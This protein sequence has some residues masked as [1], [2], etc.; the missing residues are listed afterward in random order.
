MHLLWAMQELPIWNT[1]DVMHVER[2]VSNNLLRYLTR[3]NDIM[4]V[5]KDMQ[6]VGVHQHLWL[7]SRPGSSNYFKPTA[8]YDF[9]WEVNKSFLEFVYNIPTP[10]WYAVA[11]RK[12]VGPK[13]LYAM[14]NHDHHV[15]VQQILRMNVRNLLQAGLRMTIIQLEQ[16]FQ[17]ICAKVLNLEDLVALWTYEHTQY[18]CLKYGFH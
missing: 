9:P 17:R 16:S 2:N 3:E 10:T 7:Q 15:M 5:W 12:H 4:E 13:R 1:L 14:K 6:E 8:L 11:F 18:A